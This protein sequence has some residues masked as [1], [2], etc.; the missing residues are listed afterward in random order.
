M[1]RQDIYDVSVPSDGGW[2]VFRDANGR[3]PFAAP[4]KVEREIASTEFFLTVEH[5]S[6]SRCFVLVKDARGEPRHHHLR[7]RVSE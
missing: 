5:L 3:A 2:L 7:I 6:E 1:P 4:P